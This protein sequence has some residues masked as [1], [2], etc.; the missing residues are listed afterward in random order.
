ME[1]C[2]Q[3][4]HTLYDHRLDYFYRWYH[5]KPLLV[6]GERREELRRMQQLLYKCIVYMADT[7]E[8]WV[9][10]YMPL[11]EKVIEILRYQSRLPFR[12]GAYRP[13]YL[14]DENGNLLLVEI[15][16]RFFGHGLWQSYPSEAW[17]ESFMQKHTD[18]E[19]ENSYEERFQ[20]LRSL[21]PDGQK[22][23]ALRSTDRTSEPSFYLPFYEHFGH[24][25]YDLKAEEV[26]PQMELWSKDAFVLSGLNQHDLLSYRMETLQAM[27]DARMMN[28]FRTVFIIHDKRFM[29]MIFEDAF[30]Q[31][32]LT[33]EETVF[34]RQHTILTFCYEDNCKDRWEDALAHKDDYIL[35]PFDLGKSEGI[36]AGVMTDEDTWHSLFESDRLQHY[37]LQPFIRQR[38][39]PTVW[40]GTAY[41]D[42]ICGMMLCIDDRYFDSG[43]VRTA[44]VPVSNK[45]DLRVKPVIHSDS[46]ELKAYCHIL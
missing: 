15:T 19:W 18:C 5:L 7:W 35:K 16:S 22:V 24:Q 42:Y 31:R 37:I 3:V 21:V 39:Y 9:P 34:L 30:T 2:W 25:T 23:V 40:E 29:R 1:T 26:E 8:E 12:A 43:F 4:C 44:S 13:D 36:Y 14:V 20:Y 46:E 17:A 41:D 27:A 6:T 38:T 10:A 11:P 45:V 32:C 28:D 33:E